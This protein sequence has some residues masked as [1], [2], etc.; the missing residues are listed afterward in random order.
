MTG[1]RIQRRTCNLL[2]D[3][4]EHAAEHVKSVIRHSKGAHTLV[5]RGDGSMRMYGGTDRV[6]EDDRQNVV[7]TYN[8]QARVEHLEDDLLCRLREISMTRKQA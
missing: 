4:Y 5:V 6:K 8:R 1:P 2:L 7:G 3:G